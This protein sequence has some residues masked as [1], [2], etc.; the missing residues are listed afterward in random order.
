MELH[1]YWR[2]RLIHLYAYGEVVYSGP[3]DGY[4]VTDLGDQPIFN[5]KLSFRSRSFRFHFV[6]QNA[7]GAEYQ[8]RDWFVIPGRYSYWGFTWDFLD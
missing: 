1:V 8:S 2:Q 7:L 5:V 3:Y 6:I 4:A